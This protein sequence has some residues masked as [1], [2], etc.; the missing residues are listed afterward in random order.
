MN[1]WLK[2]RVG[3]IPEYTKDHTYWTTRLITYDIEDAVKEV[4]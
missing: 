1:R 4:E 3:P 2:I